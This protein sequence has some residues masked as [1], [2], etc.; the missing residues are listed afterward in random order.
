MFPIL[1]YDPDGSSVIRRTSILHGGRDHWLVAQALAAAFT[2]IPCGCYLLL[3]ACAHRCC[4][5]GSFTAPDDNRCAHQSRTRHPPTCPI[6][7][8]HCAAHALHHAPHNYLLF[9]CRCAT[10]RFSLSWRIF[11]QRTYLLLHLPHQFSLSYLH[12]GSRNWFSSSW[13]INAVLRTRISGL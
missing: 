12:T 1:G 3:F 13:W 7:R 5:R 8:A 4:A 11:L 9:A 10:A 6:L 2:V